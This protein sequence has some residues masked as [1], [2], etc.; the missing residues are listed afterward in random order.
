MLKVVCWAQN[1]V[2]VKVGFEVAFVESVGM[3]QRK[4]CW[5]WSGKRD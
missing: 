2:R 1:S 5:N 4:I 3:A